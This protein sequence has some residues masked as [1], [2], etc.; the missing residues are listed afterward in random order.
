MKNLLC[1]AFLLFLTVSFSVNAQTWTVATVPNTKVQDARSFTS[2]PDD[3]IDPENQAKIDQILQQVEQKYSAEVFVVALNS[4][5]DVEIKPFATELFN[6]WKIGKAS[7]DNGM[8]IVLALNKKQ[9]TIE[10]GLGMEGVFPDAICYRIIQNV[11]VPLV[12]EGQVGAGLLKGVESIASILTDPNAAAEVQVDQKALMQA[13]MQKIKQT[14]YNILV[15]YLFLTIL[16]LILSVINANKKFK[17]VTGMDPYEAYKVMNTSAV[18]YRILAFLFPLTM[19]LFLLNFN[20]K[21]K[22]LRKQPRVCPTCGKHLVL[23]NEKQEDAYLSPGQQAEEMVGS[24]DYDA[25]V[26]MDCGTKKFLSYS[27][28]FTRYQS[29]PKCRFKT[30]LQTGD[31]IVSHPT[32]LSTGQ[33]A[34]VFTCAHCGYENISY[35]VIPMILLVPTGRGGGGFGGGGG[36]GFGGGMSGGG[37]ATGGW[38]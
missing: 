27:K 11:M 21:T 26:C 17:S 25:W 9:I 3:L 32:P 23:M 22:K 4:I 24:I 14:L 13:K 2:D 35:F 38:N 5:G 8:L 10:T 30:Y 29:C 28:S 36:G 37:G 19:L 12:Q 20:R 31:R 33:G 18:S 16:V 6:T 1:K 7:N 15:I 34:H